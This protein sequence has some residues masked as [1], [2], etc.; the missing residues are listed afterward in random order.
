[1]SRRQVYPRTT[2]TSRMRVYAVRSRTPSL[3]PN[4]PLNLRRSTRSHTT[5][6][7]MWG[8]CHTKLHALLVGV[9]ILLRSL[10]DRRYTAEVGDRRRRPNGNSCTGW[11]CTGYRHRSDGCLVA[12]GLSVEWRRLIHTA[13]MLEPIYRP[14]GPPRV[15]SGSN[16]CVDPYVGSICNTPSPHRRD[17]ICNMLVR[18]GARPSW[19]GWGRCGGVSA[20]G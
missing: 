18:G 8:V 20:S 15:F 1:M 5:K 4:A 19:A 13:T 9:H 17:R 6:L 10:C 12:S 2:T 16:Q 3:Q 11:R 14:H 7:L